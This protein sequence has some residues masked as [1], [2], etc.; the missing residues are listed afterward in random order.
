MEPSYRLEYL[1]R[2][3]EI[4][5]VAVRHGFG[6]VLSG[7]PITRIPGLHAMQAKAT[8]EQLPAAKRLC[9][10]MQELGPTFV[11]LGQMLSTRADLLP[12]EFVDELASLQ[13]HVPPF[14]GDE[15]RAVVAEEF[16]RPVE[17]V[18]TEFSA[19][20]VASASIA[21]VHSAR[22]RDG[23]KVAV[24]IMRPGIEQTLRSDINILY[25]LA[26]LLEGQLDLG[27]TTP[28]G[29]VE[30]FDRAISQE[31][32]F[33]IEANNA[34]EFRE[35][36]ADIEGVAV[37][38]V[39]RQFT[40]RRV[41]TLDW[42]DGTKLSQLATT[43]ADANKVM[44]R[45]V[46]ATYEQIFVAGF[47]HADP[48]PGNLVVDDDSLL[49]YLD[50]GLMGRITPEMRDTLEAI[51]VAVIFRDAEGAAR[52]LYRAGTSDGRVDLRALAAEIDVLLQRY[53][54]TSLQEQDTSQ[55]ALQLV[56]LARRHGLRLP[57][58][59]AVLARTEVALDGIARE[60]VP[61][62]DMM[63]AVRPYALRLASEQLDPEKVGGDLL[64]T[65]LGS[66]NVLKDLPA[67]L[68]QLLLD[69]ERGNFQL[70]AAT[71]AVDRLTDTIDRLGRSL[72]F[73]LGVSAFL[74]SSSILVAVLMVEGGG[75][76][77]F[78]M[79]VAAAIFVSLLAAASLV[80]GLLWNLFV[81][82]R[83]GGVRWRRFLGFVPGFRR[84]DE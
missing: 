38:R 61:G 54:G 82:G 62:W 40:T 59:Y 83:L 55:I 32:D 37:P 60:L 34:Q 13:D 66:V 41:M 24:K 69:L 23:T 12:R 44:E 42:V 28:S 74:V 63:E 81:R 70:T 39:H 5:G 53:G 78:D 71:P 20:P 6:Q 30:A 1:A 72:V 84:K 46:E 21:Q 8:G 17:D 22:M 36:L 9:R 68:D 3:R 48:H 29:I 27:I 14:P 52:T 65:A 7:L 15:A 19:E 77:V 31:V 45:L 56:D 51:F 4:L 25:T 10:V 26:E 33:R 76:G 49:T 50:F 64:R 16:D 2:A 58:E 79:A 11:K 73:G 43:G 47:F 18:F 75:Y 35:A 80:T 67:Q 57:Q